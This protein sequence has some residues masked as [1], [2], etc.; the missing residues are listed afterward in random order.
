MPVLRHAARPRSRW[1]AL[2]A[3]ALA[4]TGCAPNAPQDSLDPAGPSARSINDL[5]GPVFLVAVA[6]FIL[7]QGLIVYMVIRFRRREDD[8]S[9]PAQLHGNTR[10]E[11]GWTILPALVLAVIAVFTVPV[12]FELNEEPDEAL[13]VS[14]TGQKYWWG[15]E[16]GDQAMVP[17][18]GIVTA[19]E[20]HIPAGEPVF[21]E[22]ES[23][24]V[25]HSFWAPRLNGKRDV[26]PGRVHTWT[27]EADEPGVYSGQCAEF[28]GTSHPNMRLKVVAH[29]QAGWEAWVSSQQE[30]PEVPTDGLAAEGFEVFGQLCASCHVVDG[31]FDE[32]AE[33]SPPAPNLTHLFSRDCFAG[34]I[35]DLNDRNELEAW[36]RDPQRKAGSLM[37]IGE[38]SET[39]IDQLYAY[40]ETLE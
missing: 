29:D 12:I 19:N 32:V 36:M 2:G 26:V 30:Q 15:Y 31:Q 13:V 37:V 25:I 24:D 38:L 7:I 35:Y 6:V 5:F 18:G 1:L 22:L 23:N 21:L 11:V 4:V 8:A 40:L 20:L 10:L 39:Q 28:C 33:T 17:G 27:L 3:L 14:V 16:Y 34:C 9:F